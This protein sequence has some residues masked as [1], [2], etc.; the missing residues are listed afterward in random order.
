M[1][2]T[3]TLFGYFIKNGPDRAGLIRAFAQA[4]GSD[5]KE[6]VLFEIVRDRVANGGGEFYQAVQAHDIKITGL[7]YDGDSGY[8]FVVEGD[9][10]VRHLDGAHA[11]PLKCKFIACYDAATG[12]G[13]ANFFVTD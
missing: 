13:N 10:N 3:K 2:T 9:I 1:T 11:D 5:S 12:K 6:P 8:A 7:R 4:G